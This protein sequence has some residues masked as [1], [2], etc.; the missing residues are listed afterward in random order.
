MHRVFAA[1]LAGVA[2][3]ACRPTAPAPVPS[4]APATAHPAD[5]HFMSGM[6]AHHDQAVLIAGW[7]AEPARGANAAIRTL[8]ERVVVAQNDEIALAQQWLRTHTL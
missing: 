4:A 6:I 5:V 2:F 7:S 8:S 3:L 1:T